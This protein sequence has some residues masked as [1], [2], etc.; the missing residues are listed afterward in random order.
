MRDVPRVTSTRPVA[1]RR[2]GATCS[3]WSATTPMSPPAV[4]T[5]AGAAGPGVG[6]EGGCA[7]A[8]VAPRRTTTASNIVT[9]RDVGM[10]T[11]SS[12]TA[13]HATSPLFDRARV[14]TALERSQHVADEEQG[15]R[16]A[17]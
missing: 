7:A 10:D 2:F 14:I 3:I 1:M 16:H 5:T 13:A 12:K 11:P 8:T 17:D 15:A 6:M 4:L 9:A